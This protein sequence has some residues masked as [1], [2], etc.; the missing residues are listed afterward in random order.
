M[1]GEKIN[2]KNIPAKEF[3]FIAGPCVIESR[4]MALEIAGYLKEITGRFSG[5]KFIFKASYDKANR[6]S[7]RS[8]R[9]PGLKKGL[10]I[11]EKIKSNLDIPVLSDVHTPQQAFYAGKILDVIQIPAFLCRQTD[12]IIAAAKSGKTV[13]I[14]KGQFVSPYDMKYAVEKAEFGGC[15]NIMLTERGT[16]FGYNNLVVD[17]RSLGVMAKFGYPVIFDATHS[18]QR[19]SGKKGYSGGDRE[20]IVPLCRAA[21]AFGVSGLFLETHPYPNKALSDKSTSL[22]LS[23]VENLLGQISKIISL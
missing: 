11:L 1:A 16:F 17:F 5:I 20:F 4:S 8:F 9:G 6:T 19:P 3:I 14:K 12:L 2:K 22:K 21:A 10:R 13:N 18:L 23:R 15:R 7:V